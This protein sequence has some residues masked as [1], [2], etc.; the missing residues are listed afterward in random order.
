MTKEVL[1]VTKPSLYPDTG[2]TPDRV[3]LVFEGRRIEL[4]SCVLS[5]CPESHVMD[6]ICEAK[7]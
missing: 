1:D 2:M 7:P 6:V 4:S 5:Y 3:F